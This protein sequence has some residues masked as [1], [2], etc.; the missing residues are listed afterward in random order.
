MVS[1]NVI[2][3]CTYKPSATCIWRCRGDLKD[4]P[5]WEEAIHVDCPAKSP[6]TINL[7]KLSNVKL[8]DSNN[9]IL[10]ECQGPIEV[11][12][13]LS[14]LIDRGESITT[15]D[16]LEYVSIILGGLASH[17]TAFSPNNS[18]SAQKVCLIYN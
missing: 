6:V 3:T 5:K 18:K 8:C 15:Q 11:S 12:E 16:D 17:P 14:K 4:G 1:Q 10:E 13:N 9:T 2:N 7:I